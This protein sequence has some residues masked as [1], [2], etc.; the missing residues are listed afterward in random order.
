MAWYLVPSLVAL[1][2]EVNARYPN[3]DKSS[4]GS[5]GDT[6]HSSRESDHN[7]DPITG[8]VRAYDLDEDLDG[9]QTDSGDELAFL[10]EHLRTKRDP[11]IKYLIYGGRIYASYS[12][13]TRKA[14]TWGPYTG[15]NAHLKHMHVSVLSTH[16]GENDTSPWLPS[17]TPKPRPVHAKDIGMLFLYDPDNG[18]S[19]VVSDNG[20][21]VVSGDC[22]NRAAQIGLGLAPQSAD[23]DAIIRLAQKGGGGGGGQVDL[24]A[25]KTAVREVFADAGQE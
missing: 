14:W 9:N 7:P 10:A 4:D 11:R 24:D 5:I 12:T 1:R 2:N 16:V 6:A 25:I 18:L 20:Y 3:R 15:T 17:T 8:A 19:Y 23:V 13:S 22:F 21:E